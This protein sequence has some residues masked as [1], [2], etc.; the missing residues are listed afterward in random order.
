MAQNVHSRFGRS[1]A[2]VRLSSTRERKQLAYLRGS[3]NAQVNIVIADLTRGACE[4]Q[5][6]TDR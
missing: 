3:G 5:T 4:A 2:R 6:T 1:F